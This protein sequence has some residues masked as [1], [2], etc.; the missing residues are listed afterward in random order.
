MS[1]NFDYLIEKIRTAEFETEPFSHLHIQSFLSEEHFEAVVTAPEINTTAATSPAQLI[2]QLEGVGYKAISFPGCVTSKSE[3]LKWLEG[4][5]KKSVHKA[6]EGF[7][8]VMRLAPP[9]GSVIEALDAFMKSD[10]MKAAL[11][12]KFSLEDELVVDA[13]IQKYLHGYEI[14]PHPDTRRKALTWMFNANPGAE[15]E[16]AEI[17]TH[18]M[19]FK[20][21]WSFISGF[22][23]GNPDVDRCWVP[24]EWCTTQKQQRDNNSIVFFAPSDDTIH[25]VKANYDHLKTQRTQF[26]GNL[27]YKADPMLQKVEFEDLDIK[28]HMAASSSVLN[29]MKRTAAGRAALGIAK[30]FTERV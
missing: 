1:H 28:A 29:T 12:E 16:D 4:G 19:T 30:K 21:E 9:E 23:K 26:Y 7:G 8:M 2:E 14:S 17:H 27:W 15:S 20:P 24:W 22:W 11:A 25:A 5:S 10:E 18:Y 6:T 13:G 3:Y